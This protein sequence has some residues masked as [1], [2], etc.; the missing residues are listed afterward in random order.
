MADRQKEDV[1]KNTVGCRFRTFGIYLFTT[2]LKNK[3][4][5]ERFILDYVY[6]YLCG[7]PWSP[8]EAE[9]EPGAVRCQ[10][11]VLRTKLSSGRA[12]SALHL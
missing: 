6:G 10:S 7:C 12:V 11:R 1:F 8:E 2:W 9:S 4:L 5:K 3:V